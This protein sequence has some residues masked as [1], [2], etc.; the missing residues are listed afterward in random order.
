MTIYRRRLDAYVASL[1][2][3]KV[4]VDARLIKLHDGWVTPAD[5]ANVIYKR[6]LEELFALETPP[7]AIVCTSDS[8]AA[9]LMAGRGNAASACPN[10]CPLPA[11]GINTSLR[12]LIRR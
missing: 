11:T 8:F 5:E 3:R 10:N 1:Y 9:G 7:T 4:V 2:H 6:F 12:W